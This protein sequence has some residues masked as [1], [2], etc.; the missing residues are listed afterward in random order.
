LSNRQFSLQPSSAGDCTRSIPAEG[1][2][3]LHIGL[4]PTATGPVTGTL[5]VDTAGAASTE[6]LTG[7]ATPPAPVVTVSPSSL[8]FGGVE[9][10]STSAPQQVT[11]TNTGS[12]EL[13]I[14]GVDVSGDF[15]GSPQPKDC[16][17][18]AR[19]A[20]GGHCTIAVTFGPT[21]IGP[22]S[23]TLT[24]TGFG[25]S[26]ASGS[27]TVSLTGRGTRPRPPA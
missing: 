11:V 9:F 19:L 20:P 15:A 1:S 10:G 13:R 25:A 17:A 5:T 22:K 4:T 24:L 7:T 16:L 12:A 27:W 2:C 8:D 3:T 26:L 14:T 18:L 21:T 23:G 6:T